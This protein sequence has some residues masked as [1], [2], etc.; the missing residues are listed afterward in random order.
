VHLRTTLP[1]LAATALVATLVL[2]GCGNDD[3]DAASSGD[4]ATS[5][6]SESTS[7][8]A[9]ETPSEEPSV[10]EAPKAQLKGDMVGK[11][12]AY[13]LPEGWTDTT[14]QARQLQAT[15][16]TAAAEKEPADGFSDNLNVGYQAGSSA[17][18]DQLEASVPS[19]LANLVKKGDLEVLPRTEVGGVEAIHHRAPAK[20]GAT[21][22]FLEQFAAVTD[23]GDVAIIT[24][25]FSRKVPEA[26]RD[27]VISTVID[28]WQWAA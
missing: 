11:G 1:R 23:D 28:S 17:T 6:A 15:I 22:Y 18:L 14:K 25:S 20:L 4:A 7:E 2:A 8:S 26:E 13:D 5:S 9:S 24:F 19:Q 27:K 16:D 3:P 12:Y 21:E 10:N